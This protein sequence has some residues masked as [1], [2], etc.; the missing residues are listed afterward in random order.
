M[1]RKYL[2]LGTVFLLLLGSFTSI[3][4]VETNKKNL[5][6]KEL[7]ID[8]T[9]VTIQFSDTTL[10]ASTLNIKGITK[11]IQKTNYENSHIK[12]KQI[13]F[14]PSDCSI[15]NRE[16]GFVYL[17]LKGL[18][19]TGTQGEPMLP[20]KTYVIELPRNS[21][22]LDV[23]MT[24]VNYK[25][26]KNR[27]MIA[28]MPKPVFW[29]Q[30]T[31]NLEEI[32]NDF[33]LNTEVYSS[34]NFYPGS[35]L[36]YHS[37]NTNKKKL[38]LVQVYPIQYIPKDGKTILITDGE[39]QV[40]YTN[41]GN[42]PIST[43]S[44][45][46]TV[47]LIITPSQLYNQAKELKNYHNNQGTTTQIVNTTWINE[48]YDEA[49][50]PP[51]DG[52][53]NSSLRGW[54][55]IKNYDYSLAKKI[56]N[57]LNDTANHTNLEYVTLFGNA[58]LVPPSFYYWIAWTPTD[59]FYSSPDYDLIPNYYVG[60]L[61]VNNEAE[62]TQIV[63]KIKNW[64]GSTDLFKNITISGGRSFGTPFFTGELITIDSVNQGFLEGANISKQF[65]T[66]G[67]FTKNN[68]LN[69]LK[70]DTGI[71]YNIGHGGGNSLV[72][73]DTNPLRP[74][75]HILYEYEIMDLPQSDKTP[76]V[77]S[78]ACSNGAYDT[79][80]VDH[81]YEISI[82]ESI[83]LSDAGGI[84]Y[85]GGSRGN[86]GI[87][88]FTLEK[89]YVNISKEPHMAGMLTNVLESYHDG[90]STLG[91]ITS[92]AMFTYTKNND[93][94]Y[95][96]EQYTFLSFILLGDPALKIPAR[97]T[98]V[99]YQLP[100]S[101]VEDPLDYRSDYS[102]SF[103]NGTIPLGVVDETAI[104]KS[105]TDSPTVQ[106]K[107]ID[108]LFKQGENYTI[109][110]ETKSTIDNNVTYDFEPTTS[111]LFNIRTITEDGK[112]GWLYYW[113]FRVV[114]DDFNPSTP[115]WGVTRWNSIQDAI[116]G[117]NKDDA[118]YIFNGTYY[119]K[120]VVYKA[121]TL[122]GEDKTQ[123][124]INGQGENNVITITAPNTAIVTLT[125]LNSGN[126]KTNAGIAIKAD[127]VSIFYCIIKF[128][129][130][131]VYIHDNL[132]LLGYTTQLA[133]NSISDNKYGIYS[134]NNGLRLGKLV[135]NHI[136]H[137]TYAIYLSNSR[138]N[139]ISGN[140]I[141]NN[142]MGIFL[143]KSKLN[144]ITLNDFSD[145]LIHATFTKSSLNRWNSNYW[146]NWIGLRLKSG[147]NIP[148]YIFGRKGIFVGLIPTIDRDKNPKY[149]PFE[150][151]K[152]YL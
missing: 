116:D 85:I 124:I 30:N 72:F 142:D 62:A 134:E 38:V 31:E 120:I 1:N 105:Q 125:I 90:I 137:N 83:L 86:A 100:H 129:E 52:Y 84:A 23:V 27:L 35:I 8:N 20:M 109:E 22:V 4:G 73:A 6:Q 26:I 58:R 99:T 40:I 118:I 143:K 49:D 21:H 48:N 106:M 57:F 115:G 111:S 65:E 29:S 32:N 147:L 151:E 128:N 25:E 16:L 144:L 43:S 45:Y 127:S 138:L 3:S 39:I 2:V 78:I 36:K 130:N 88:I 11:N 41:E 47:N 104:V 145:N 141:S 13:N 152:T 103:F 64:E 68:F 77:V 63:N 70:G 60:R 93:M 89:G 121:L 74:Y 140:T 96:M 82:G 135:F 54:G 50:D 150:L 79:H 53:W 131:G 92:N 10:D 76:I 117:S 107:L 37:G 114:D 33:I 81:G 66:D 113:A 119:E 148:K 126:K 123:T 80:L 46:D 132:P 98:D 110:T 12:T 75:D 34:D 136:H 97:P 19:P 67:T 133:Y 24:D 18:E 44:S 15:Q 7:P 91:N 101:I 14:N 112:E 108:S 102:S 122:M 146:D 71:I 42:H 61:P 17:G 149:Y 69:S 56:I 28:P 87:P 51:Y 55:D 139:I 95:L 9:L 59:F 5:I 94:S